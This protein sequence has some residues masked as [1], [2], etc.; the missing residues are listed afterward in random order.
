[1]N[2]GIRGVCKI[3]VSDQPVKNL[4][5]ASRLLQAGASACLGKREL[6][7]DPESFFRKVNAAANA[8]SGG[9]R[10]YLSRVRG[11]AA[12]VDRSPS[13]SSMSVDQSYPIPLDE[14]KRL[15]ILARKNL[16]NSTRER[17]FDLITKHVAKVTG[18]PV[19]LLTF[20]DRTTQWIN[21]NVL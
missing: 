9:T 18:F 14:A 5:L 15:E 11:A 1:M 19:C 12:G 3:I 8:L 17:Q 20:I 6:A 13:P 4:L 2:L 10:H 16:N 7:D 21:T